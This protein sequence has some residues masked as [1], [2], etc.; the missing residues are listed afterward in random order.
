MD[1]I[2]KNEDDSKL[3]RAVIIDLFKVFNTLGQSQHLAKL[4]QGDLEDTELEWL[5]TTY[6][7]ELKQLK[8]MKH[9]PNHILTV[10]HSVK[11]NSGT[12]LILDLFTNFSEIL[13]NSEAT[14]FKNDNVNCIPVKNVD[15]I[16]FMSNDDFKNISW[17]FVENELVVNLKAGRTKCILLG[18]LENV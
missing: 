8:K 11:I 5:P 18:N 1:K 3:K 15:R 2:H 10:Q 7:E 16:K 9:C 4:K 12:N 13:K 6:F 14:Q 17:Y